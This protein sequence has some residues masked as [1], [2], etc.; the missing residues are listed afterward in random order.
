M[1]QLISDE[2]NAVIEFSKF[3]FILFL[4]LY[5][6]IVPPSVIYT[7]THTFSLSFSRRV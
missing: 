4:R 2:Y 5:V 7:N 3:E 1:H 6:L